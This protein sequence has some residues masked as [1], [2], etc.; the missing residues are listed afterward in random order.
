MSSWN[1]FHP[2]TGTTVP[3]KN[4]FLQLRPIDF[5][6]WNSKDPI[7][8]TDCHA[9]NLMGWRGLWKLIWYTP[10][11]H[12]VARVTI[13][14][15]HYTFN[16]FF[17]DSFSAVMFVVHSSPHLQVCWINFMPSCTLIMSPAAVPILS[18][19]LLN[20]VFYI[21]NYLYCISYLYDRR[22]NVP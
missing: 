4:K 2:Y 16:H 15:L 10:K 19:Q 13:M 6:N 3:K 18:F 14:H 7:E 8:F 12:S 5:S 22:S 11:L 20:V 17:T 21:I 1:I 9:Y